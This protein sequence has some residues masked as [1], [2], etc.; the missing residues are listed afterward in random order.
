MPPYHHPQVQ[1][2]AYFD[3]NCSDGDDDL[4]DDQSTNPTES[5]TASTDPASDVAFAQRFSDIL[6]GEGEGEEA[7]SLP[8][9]PEEEDDRVCRICFS[10]GDGGEEGRLFRPCKCSGTRCAYLSCHLIYLFI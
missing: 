1:H 3:D 10:G 9:E 5:E 6:M 7:P 4:N 8:V 2:E